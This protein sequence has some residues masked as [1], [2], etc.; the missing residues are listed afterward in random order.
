MRAT[1]RRPTR[2]RGA[3]LA[4][5]LCLPVGVNA[6]SGW[7]VV[8]TLDW[9]V[10]SGERAGLFST[11]EDDDRL[12]VTGDAGRVYVSDDGGDTWRSAVLEPGAVPPLRKR[13]HTLD[14]PTSRFVSPVNADGMPE[15]SQVLGFGSLEKK[16]DDPVGRPSRRS[17]KAFSDDFAD[18]GGALE[19]MEPDPPPSHLHAAN[20]SAFADRARRRLTLEIVS[21]APDEATARGGGVS[22]RTSDGGRTWLETSADAPAR[23]ASPS[24]TCA[25]RVVAVDGA[26][27]LDGEEVGLAAT[28][29]PTCAVGRSV[30][31]LLHGGELLRLSRTPVAPD[32]A[33]VAGPVDEAAMRV[34]R[35]RAGLEAPPIRP[36]YAALLP[37]VDVGLRLAAIDLESERV[38][39][40]LDL[41][42]E[43][44]G[45]FNRGP[46]DP[47]DA[48][49]FLKWDLTKLLPA[50]D[51]EAD[52]RKVALRR[53]RAVD[54]EVARA[55]STWHRA[56]LR[57]DD[58]RRASDPLRRA[59]LEL[60]A[61]VAAV[62][63]Q[64]LTGLNPDDLAPRRDP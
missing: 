29:V 11:G 40:F 30:V 19:G 12:W 48:G 63:L 39:S 24:K 21:G 57:L 22:W 27:Q 50:V 43:G 51:E 33:G 59:Q 6:Q 35:R 16:F 62:T 15:P 7:H 54:A 23:P 25:G 4:A 36:W 52:R 64:H 61:E 44:P 53:A 45:S 5:S 10:A 58:L 2:L 56:R 1:R 18:A 49:V 41:P 60:R 8:P 28:H 46:L 38:S 17:L 31:W 32:A 34:A 3:L 9:P 14:A 37:R 55:L 47:F 26:L 13:T 20:Q 42:E